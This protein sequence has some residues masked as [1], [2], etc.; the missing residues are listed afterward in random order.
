MEDINSK[1]YDKAALK[2]MMKQF[3][4]MKEKYPEHILFFRC[5]AFYEFYF[6]DA[7]IVAKELSMILTRKTNTPGT[8]CGFTHGKLDENVAEM[9]GKGYKVAICEEFSEK[10]RGELGIVVR[11]VVRVVTP[12]TV[13]SND[14]DKNNIFIANIE[15][16]K[17]N[18]FIISYGDV[19]TGELFLVRVEG[20]FEDVVSELRNLAIVEIVLPT[21]MP[22]LMVQTLET[23]VG[24][25][26]SYEDDC[27]FNDEYKGLF[28]HT[29]TNQCEYISIA[30]LLHYITNTQHIE[31]KHLQAIQFI[32]RLDYM[33]L[34]HNSQM[35]LDIFENAKT[36]DKKKSL[37][38]VLDKTTTSMGSRRLKQWIDKPLV[39]KKM[40]Q[41]RLDSVEELLSNYFVRK[42]VIEYMKEVCD[43]EKVVGR[44]A[45][46]TVNARD[47]V[48]LRTTLEYI[49]SI[50]GEV[51][52]FDQS[53]IKEMFKDTP[54]FQELYELLDT[55]ITKEE[56][57]NVPHSLKE[58]NLIQDGYNELLDTY[59]TTLATSETWL[60]EYE[61]R[62]R[63]ATG[64]ARLKVNTN[65]KDGP[66]YFIEVPKKQIHLVPKDRYE[67]GPSYTNHVRYT[68]EELRLK[69]L[70]IT[71]AHNGMREL[72]YELFKEIREKVQEAIPFIQQLA[73]SLSELDV[74]LAFSEISEE[75]S[76][77]KPIIN[78]KR[79][80]KIQGGRHPMIERFL[81]VTPY[82]KND[83]YMNDS[84]RIMLLLTGPN[85]SGK[86]TY[87]RQTAAIAIMCQ[88]GCFVPADYVEI[89]IYDK[90]FTRIGASDD[91]VSGKSTFMVEMT[92][93]QVALKH[94]TPNSLILLDE[95]GRGTS[96]YDG[97]SLAQ[98]IIEYVH[99]YINCH[100][101]FSTHYHELAHLE[102]TLSGIQNIRVK[103]EEEDDEIVFLHQIEDGAAGKS[104]GIHI[105]K[106]SGIPKEI[107]NRAKELLAQVEDNDKFFQIG[108]EGRV[109][110]S[111]EQ[112]ILDE[113]EKLNLYDITPLAA[114]NL[115]SEMKKKIA[116]K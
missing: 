59:R 54:N 3:V 66:N 115:I 2:P 56:I 63:D 79:V 110:S 83:A 11:E 106:L 43:L 112:S 40:I 29:P 4:D 44:I 93:T 60:K 72:E 73:K 47:L 70:S 30:R 42:Q 8:T 67:S 46:K 23:E 57:R 58:G 65:S 97:V 92:E 109:L 51:K 90:I 114:M 111:V 102:Q 38:G 55:S 17:E 85:M 20:G 76:Y 16:E 116:N 103:V 31:L 62:E 49:P 6:E 10:D 74:L 99:G 113:I 101:L 89:P 52:V 100:T 7:P 75:Y 96:T 9:V 108:T 80:A 14:K 82:V 41:S 77:V 95:I 86:S 107:T 33:Q 24:C 87:M 91:I 104:Y 105:A 88:I 45:F 68:T 32:D 1:T 26:L 28:T 35:N 12:G 94:A 34:D 71:V 25:A 78:E 22:T 13:L 39:D 64:I 81:G 98:A 69:Q 5:G 84:D 27:S 61:V 37:F 53:Y 15:I 36:R 21:D 19:S 48:Q 50:L 18:S